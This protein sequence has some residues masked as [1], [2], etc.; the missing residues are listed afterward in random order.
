[1][2]GFKLDFVQ[3]L[4]DNNLLEKADLDKNDARINVSK[5]DTA[6]KDFLKNYKVDENEL[7]EVS[8][9]VD[10]ILS[11][12][13]DD[14]G[15]VVVDDSETDGKKDVLG[16]FFNFLLNSKDVKAQVDKNGD[17]KISKDEL[18]EFAK[19]I[20]SKDGDLKSFTLKDMFG[21]YNQINTNQFKVGDFAAINQTNFN[22]DNF[23]LQN[24]T[25]QT[26][27][28]K[29]KPIA[30]P[31]EKFSVEISSIAQNNALSTDQK[32]TQLNDELA[33]QNSVLEKDKQ[34]MQNALSGELASITPPS[35][36][37][38][39]SYDSYI[40]L[41]SQVDDENKTYQTQLETMKQ[42]LVDKRDEL[43][44]WQ[45]QNEQDN[46]DCINLDIEVQLAK[47]GVEGAQE[48]FDTANAELLTLM[49]SEDADEA[50]ISSAT[51]KVEDA[52]NKL[53]D[54]QKALEEKTQEYE[55][56]VEEYNKSLD[57]VARCFTEYNALDSQL[58]AFQNQI[59]AANKANASALKDAADLWNT[60]RDGNEN[61][62]QDNYRIYANSVY[63]T[64]SNIGVIQ[65]TLNSLEG[66]ES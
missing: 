36:A 31:N 44:T 52:Q 66:Q 53:N 30:V 9:D 51:A 40:A 48:F 55:K 25:P 39:S 29:F 37:V 56:K 21:S 3:F 58:V 33:N 22:Q 43:H 47:A 28:D 4:R 17:G 5:Y 35:S 42:G 19:T 32:R 16:G 64:M 45:T 10:E 23:N 18:S 24:V 12:D 50:T 38:D 7:I 20:A 8:I 27:S 46:E 15:N 54:A 13:F 41:V 60:S 63:E 49:S 2:A 62:R 1:M 59:T 26:T 11:M 57:E 6:L 14:I 34:N 65:K 61:S